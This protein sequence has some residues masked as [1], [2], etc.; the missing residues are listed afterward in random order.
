MDHHV[1]SLLPSSVQM[2]DAVARSCQSHGQQS[3]YLVRVNTRTPLKRVLRA[4]VVVVLSLAK[5]LKQMVRLRSTALSKRPNLV[6]Q[7]SLRSP[8]LLI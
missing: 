1:K 8:V 3:I 5:L 4:Q 2:L 7:K 6:A